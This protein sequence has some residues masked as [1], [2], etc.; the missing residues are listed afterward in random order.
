M[1]F[2]GKKIISV[3][4]EAKSLVVLRDESMANILIFLTKRR[5]LIGQLLRL[6]RSYNLHERDL[7]E[8]I[9]ES[10]GRDSQSNLQA[11]FVGRVSALHMHFPEMKAQV[12]FSE[13]MNHLSET[14]DELQVARERVNRI[15]KSFNTLIV[16]FPNNLIAHMFSFSQNEF[17]AATSISPL[18]EEL[19]KL[20]NNSSSR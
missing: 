7:L 2:V 20:A 9:A 17:L 18:D 6:V 11:S 13:T 15:T 19:I 12:L 5:D 16:K 10:F 1:I 8:N 4:N 3:Y 14:E